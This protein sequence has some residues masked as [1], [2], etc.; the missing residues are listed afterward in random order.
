MYRSLKMDAAKNGK[1]RLTL[2]SIFSKMAQKWPKNCIFFNFSANFSHGYWWDRGKIFFLDKGI[3]QVTSTYRKLYFLTFSHRCASSE[4]YL[5]T[6]N[7]VNI[8]FPAYTNPNGSLKTW[9]S[10]ISD[11]EFHS[12]AFH[13]VRSAK[14]LNLQEKIMWIHTYM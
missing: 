6:R 10:K 11:G 2:K 5:S 12:K 14:L 4:K 1:G 7:I 8:F 13:I 9:I 3:G